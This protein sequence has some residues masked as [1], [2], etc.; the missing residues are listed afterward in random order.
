MLGRPAW[1]TWSCCAGATTGWCTGPSTC[2]W[3]TSSRCSAGPTG[4]SW[5]SGRRRYACRPEAGGEETQFLLGFSEGGRDQVLASV[6]ESAREGDL[7][8]VAGER[9]VAPGEDEP[10]LWVGGEYRNQ[11][12]GRAGVHSV[13]RRCGVH[14]AQGTTD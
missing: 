5:R 1:T 13:L 10:R 3:S 9:L 7:A 6:G 4:R 12:S 14:A 11:Y 8:C 2:A